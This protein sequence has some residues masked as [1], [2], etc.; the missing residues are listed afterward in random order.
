MES[1]STVFDIIES[2]TEP[3]TTLGSC[4]CLPRV[5][6]GALETFQCPQSSHVKTIAE[7]NGILT[8][9]L[10]TIRYESHAFEND[11]KK[12]KWGKVMIDLQSIPIEISDEQEPKNIHR[13]FLSECPKPLLSVETA[14]FVLMHHTGSYER[15]TRN[16]GDKRRSYKTWTDRAFVNESTS[17][18]SQ[19]VPKW[20]LRFM[21]IVG[22]EKARYLLSPEDE[23]KFDV[24]HSGSVVT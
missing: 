24:S 8:S 23:P 10:N 2:W 21:D 16:G 20:L 9:E 12:N 3:N 5:T 22:T 6:F 13:P 19:H 15:Y 14:P 11:F 1:N 4:H 7:E 18:C 17:F